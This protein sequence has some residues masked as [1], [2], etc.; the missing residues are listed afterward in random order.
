MDPEHN[1]DPF[2][3]SWGGSDDM[4]FA[5]ALALARSLGLDDELLTELE[6]MAMDLLEADVEA[7]DCQQARQMLDEL[8][9][10]KV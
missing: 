8:F 7:S 2:R 3:L 6:L 10:R 9:A 5:I 4:G 1:M